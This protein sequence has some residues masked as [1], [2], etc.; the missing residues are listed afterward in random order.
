M[1]D[2]VITACFLL[3]LALMFVSFYDKYFSKREVMSDEDMMRRYMM[4]RVR[5]KYGYERHIKDTPW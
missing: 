1:I 5:H 3:A 4:R 2:Y